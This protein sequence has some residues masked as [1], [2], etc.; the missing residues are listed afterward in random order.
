[1]FDSFLHWMTKSC[2]IKAIWSWFMVF[3][4]KWSNFSKGLCSL[5]RMNCFPWKYSLKKSWLQTAA[6]A[7]RRNSSPGLSVA[8]MWTRWH[9]TSCPCQLKWGWL[10]APNCFDV[11]GWLNI[12]D[13]FELGLPGLYHFWYQGESVVQGRN[14]H[15]HAKNMHFSR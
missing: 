10:H 14:L 11:R 3:P 1:M 13:C 4:C 12:L 15:F 7:P 5:N 9:K 8:E 6:A 2:S